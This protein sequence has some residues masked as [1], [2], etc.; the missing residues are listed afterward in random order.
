M[1]ADID[2]FEVS[3]WQT[4]TKT[5][6]STHDVSDQSECGDVVETLNCYCDRTRSVCDKMAA[7]CPTDSGLPYPLGQSSID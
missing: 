4:Q 5:C 1:R 6:Q 3:F 2:V 7:S